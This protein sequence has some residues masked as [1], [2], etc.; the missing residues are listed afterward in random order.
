MAAI[1]LEIET[2]IT[3]KRLLKWCKEARDYLSI[4]LNDLRR[5]SFYKMESNFFSREQLAEVLAEKKICEEVF[6]DSITN[7]IHRNHHDAFNA[8]KDYTFAVEI[9]FKPGVTD[10]PAHS[11]KEALALLGMDVTV[12]SGSVY[13]LYGNINRDQATTIATD[14]L[15][16]PLIESIETY[17]REEFA[18]RNRF[19]NVCMPVP[20]WEGG[21]RVESISLDLDDQGLMELSASR[22]WALSLDEMKHIRKHYSDKKKL[23]TDV[24]IE[25]FAQT[26]S[27]HCKH[28]IFSSDIEY[29]ESNLSPWNVRL[30]NRSISN[31]Y[32]TYIKGATRKIKGDRNLEWLI[33]VFSDNAGIVRFDPNVDLCIKVETHN[34]PSALDPYGG[35]LTGILGVNRDILGCGMGARPIANTNVFC[36]APP[37]WPSMEEKDQLPK[38]LKHPRRVLEGVH[39]GIEDG[40][41]KSG[42]PTV[43]GAIYFDDD[44][45]GKPLVFCG[46]V[47]VM[48]QKLRDGTAT[49]E[50]FTNHGDRIV[51]VGGAIGYDGIHGA[52][53]S[54]MELN[55]SSPATAV[56][57]GDPLTQKR[58]L[59]FLMEAR[60]NMLY[61]GL[62]DNG[63]GGLSSSVGEMAIQTNGAQIDLARCPLKYPGLRPYELLISESQERMTVAVPERKMDQFLLLAR[64]R[65]VEA[66]DIGR[67]TDSGRFIIHYGDE[68]VG[69]LDI[70]FLHTS[71]PAMQLKACWDGARERKSW[72]SQSTAKIPIQMA[73][74]KD[75]FFESALI[76][77]LKSPNIV[78]KEPWVR[79]YDHEVQAAT[80]IKPFCGGSARGPSDCGVVW[81]FPH[82]G[83]KDCAMA[84]GC[85]LAP[86]ISLFDPYFMAQ[87]AVDEAIRN[88]VASGGD[89][90]TCCLL[91][92]FCWPD[93][94]K[95]NEN[96]DGDYKLGQLV[97]TCVGLYDICIAYGTPLVSGKDSMK[98]NF[99]G[100][101]QKGEKLTIGI[102]PTLLVTAMSRSSISHTTTSD[103]K[104]PG[105]LIYLVGR[106][107][108]GLLG[109]ELG[110]LY[111][112]SSI[113]DG[114]FN[115]LPAMD[116]HA[117]KKLYE[118]VFH[119]LQRQ[120]I[121]SCHDLS[122]GG[123][124]V[125]I[126]ES[127]IGGDRG[128]EIADG[129][130]G[131][132]CTTPLETA[133]FLFNEA[134]GRF[135]VTVAP[136]NK[137][138]FENLFA[139]IDTIYLGK[140]THD[141][142]L[143]LM[144]NNS[145]TVDLSMNDLLDSWRREL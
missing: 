72:K 98:N 57:I 43:N 101:N 78:S 113:D 68:I 94:I 32:N 92:N 139:P 86:R 45:A 140:V 111:R 67:F 1:R 50:N 91:D 52:T 120:L 141:H 137:G 70:Q 29:T 119:A 99:S 39:L 133:D 81:A 7:V 54:S 123:L 124:L 116:T 115:S 83:E 5:I 16:N 82:G 28:K 143:R 37:D 77:L 76:A 110:E 44:Y 114:T 63:A 129:H 42:I 10:N 134:P 49:S 25:V 71:L 87:F 4:P 100:E 11:A 136:G 84:I 19:K 8:R 38:G 64:N 109:S 105:D 9:S 48:P 112:I 80:H 96:P 62:T 130:I 3:D 85:G 142:R 75:D 118:A 46:T 51:M 93:P 6:L 138:Q 14:L 17:H 144:N 106:K 47:G 125:A 18:D 20:R 15:A 79:R 102:L 31:L 56:Q 58:V 90:H 41:N 145:K 103:F 65:G 121:N 127:M 89:I 24:E 33:S 132:L 40:G 69:D 97:R 61:S 66:T 23:P 36:L 35:S 21:T 30:G 12:A 27:E 55:A 131:K 104:N 117:N 128:V 59:D 26:W 73:L 135:V 108:K 95:S 107:S 122:D 34:S 53:F 22:C 74:A 60:D 13:F 126:A 88:V 2:T